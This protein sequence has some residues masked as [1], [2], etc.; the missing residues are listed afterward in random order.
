MNRVLVTGGTKDDAI[1]IGVFVIN[2][3]KTNA[4]LFDKIIV[5]HDGISKKLQNVINS[6]F[7]TEFVYYKYPAK[8][9]NDEVLSYFSKMIFCK[10]ECFKL[11][12][13]YDSVVWSD[14]DV[15]ILKK[16]DDICSPLGNNMNGLSCPD[17]LRQMLFKNI[18]NKEIVEAFDIDTEGVCTPIFAINKSLEKYMQIYEWCYQKTSEWDEDLYLPEQCIFSMAVQRFGI[19]MVR[20]PFDKY[21]CFP[22]EAKGDEY[23]LHAFGPKKYWSGLDNPIWNEMYAEWMSHGGPKYRKW[24]KKVLRKWLFI[25]TRLLGIRGKE[26]G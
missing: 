13:Q 14:Y 23:I 21:A 11:L 19:P 15:V 5:F 17:S 2:V 12:E 24:K 1:P 6:F 10:Y 8:S 18:V 16:L 26:K 22:T 4:H 7:P 3:A 20:F 9:K 25:K